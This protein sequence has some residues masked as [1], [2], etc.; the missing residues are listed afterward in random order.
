MTLEEMLENLTRSKNYV[1]FGGKTED[2]IQEIAELLSEL[3]HKRI[4]DYLKAHYKQ[5]PM[6]FVDFDSIEGYGPGYL[7]ANKISREEF[8]SAIYDLK[9]EVY[10]EPQTLQISETDILSVL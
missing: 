1:V 7:G 4:G 5:Y 9:V 8:L 10:A 3:T 6:L 2:E